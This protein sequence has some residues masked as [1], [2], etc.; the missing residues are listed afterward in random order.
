MFLV[1]F[2]MGKYIH[3]FIYFERGVNIASKNDDPFVN[4]KIRAEQL[5]LI[6]PNGEQIGV[7]PREAAL[8]LAKYSN[9][10]LVMINSQARP[11]VCKIMD[12]NKYRYQKQKKQKEANKKQR[13]NNTSLK[14]FRLSPVI[15][16]HDFE[17]RLKNTRKYLE[18]GNKI[19]ISIRFKGRQMAHTEIGREVMLRFAEKVKDIA[20]IE[21]YP[22]QDGRQM[23]MFL[24]PIKEIKEANDGKEDKKDKKE[25]TQGNS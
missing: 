12:Y 22:K 25:N 11:P 1:K 14:E 16:I 3:L 23:L 18:K 21:Q 19:K 2:K 17:T 13:E 9:L 24:N 15:D 8:T 10:D 6:G 7:K 5:L 20:E 4:E